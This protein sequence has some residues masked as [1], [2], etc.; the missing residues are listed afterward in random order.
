VPTR[1]YDQALASGPDAYLDM[2]MRRHL[3]DM[4]VEPVN[5][6]TESLMKA[7]LHT[8]LTEQDLV[9][10]IGASNGRFIIEAA[11]ATDVRA[12]LLGID[13]SSEAYNLFPPDYLN[14]ESFA[15]VQAA[16]EHLPLPDNSVRIVTAHNVVF[17]S[18]NLSVM[19]EE[20]KRV[21]E[22]NGLIAVSTNGRQHASWRHTL[23]LLVAELVSQETGEYFD[24]PRAPARICYLEDMPR[25]IAAVGGL[26]VLDKVVQSTVA[27]INP[28]NIYEF[29]YSI[30]L[31]ANQVKMAPE[32]HSVWRQI[33]EREIRRFIEDRVLPGA[34]GG[35]L[36]EVIHRG[37]F[38]LRNIKPS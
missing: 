11:Q 10:D 38:V 17:R 36:A 14:R 20:M 33:V 31:S 4:A 16:A 26:T 27:K 30:K 32:N 9:L 13:I 23:E 21:V 1:Y 18:S 19:F 34:W 22:P 5:F 28:K 6:Y 2:V 25:I 37:M 8:T 7:L 15:F 12:R 3:S 29:L 24:L 35:G